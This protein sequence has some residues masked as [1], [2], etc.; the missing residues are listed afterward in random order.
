MKRVAVSIAIGGILASIGLW[1]ILRDDRPTRQVHIGEQQ[2]EGESTLDRLEGESVGH[3]QDRDSPSRTVLPAPDPVATTPGLPTMPLKARG[4]EKRI[5]LQPAEYYLAS[6]IHNPGKKHPTSEQLAALTKLV[7]EESSASQAE[8]SRFYNILEQCA[9][10]KFNDGS[11]SVTPL[12]AVDE[13][14]GVYTT[15][16]SRR[17]ATGEFTSR[18]IEVRLGEFAEFDVARND[19]LESMVKREAAIAAMIGGW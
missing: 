2:A 17:S 19:R 13:Y 1:A 4:T 12:Q 11:F 3:A 15:Q 10:Q 5:V 7:A 14:A 8:E 9:G 18:T 6:P 16:I